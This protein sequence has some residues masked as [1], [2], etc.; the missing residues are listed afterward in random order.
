M[1]FSG[2]EVH[3]GQRE[4]RADARGAPLR[5]RLPSPRDWFARRITPERPRASPTRQ[6]PPFS[7]S[8][9]RTQATDVVKYLQFKAVD[10]S[11]VMHKDKKIYKARIRPSPAA[12]PTGRPGD[13]RGPS[14][15]SPPSALSNEMQFHCEPPQ[16]RLVFTLCTYHASGA[17][18]HIYPATLCISL[19]GSPRLLLSNVCE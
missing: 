5:T 4:A 1:A 11:Y 16:T 12:P 6:V 8:S 10:G 18:A 2:A 17:T 7:L 14:Q 13:A 3:H 9:L 19:A 15:G